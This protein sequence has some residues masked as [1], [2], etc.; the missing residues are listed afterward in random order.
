MTLGTLVPAVITVQCPSRCHVT[1]AEA[2]SQ[3]IRHRLAVRHGTGETLRCTVNSTAVQSWPLV[4]YTVHSHPLRR[5]TW[6]LSRGREKHVYFIFGHLFNWVIKGIYWTFLQTNLVVELQRFPE[7]VLLSTEHRRAPSLILMTLL[8]S[9]RPRPRGLARHTSVHSAQVELN[10]YAPVPVWGSHTAYLG[11][12]PETDG[13]GP[14]V[15]PHPAADQGNTG[16]RTW[17]GA[18]TG[19][20]VRRKKR[21]ITAK[22]L[23]VACYIEWWAAL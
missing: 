5:L 13:G 23:A 4:M 17:T 14:G 2:E 21:A 8:P 10:N 16:N 15:P 9:S 12:S 3:L 20:L 7:P 6:S 19:K 22:V 11:H 1:G 18:G